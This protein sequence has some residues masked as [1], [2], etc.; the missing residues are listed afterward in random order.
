M[1]C[2]LF[3]IWPVGPNG[4]HVTCACGTWWLVTLLLPGFNKFKF[5]K[6]LRP[7]S[8]TRDPEQ[9]IDCLH[10]CARRLVVLTCFWSPHS[11]IRSLYGQVDLYIVYIPYKCKQIYARW[12]CGGGGTGNEGSLVCCGGLGVLLEA[13]RRVFLVEHSGIGIRVCHVLWQRQQIRSAG[14]LSRL[15]LF[16]SLFLS[17]LEHEVYKK[18]YRVADLVRPMMMKITMRW[19]WLFFLLVSWISA[20][21]QCS[22]CKCLCATRPVNCQVLAWLYLSV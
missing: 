20:Y 19:H 5:K 6:T 8:W 11:S 22:Y 16:A 4:L 7:G 21:V 18:Y 14:L 15:F 12:T 17:L 3:S 13:R 2:G 1:A 10:H 9:G